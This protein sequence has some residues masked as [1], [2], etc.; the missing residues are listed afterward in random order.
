VG[1]AWVAL[2]RTA[3]DPATPIEL[4]GRLGLLL[5]GKDGHRSVLSFQVDGG[6][7]VRIDVVRNPEKL[8]RVGPSRGSR[9]K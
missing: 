2:G 5:P 6:R 9:S 1:R 8:R 3:A 7:I 4:N